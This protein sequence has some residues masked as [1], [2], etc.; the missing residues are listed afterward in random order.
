MAFVML[1]IEQNIQNFTPV[2]FFCFVAFSTQTLTNFVTYRTAQAYTEHSINFAHI[3]QRSAWYRLPVKHQKKFIFTIKM[4][5]KSFLLKGSGIFEVNLGV[6][7]NVSN[8][9]FN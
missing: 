7:A 4:A 1:T 6:F 3:I 9:L 5:T 2:T 8:Q